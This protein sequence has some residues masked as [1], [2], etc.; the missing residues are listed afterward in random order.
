VKIVVVHQSGTDEIEG[1]FDYATDNGELDV[2]LADIVIHTYPRGEWLK[3]SRIKEPDEKWPP[4]VID[5]I[6]DLDADESTVSIKFVEDAETEDDDGLPSA[7]PE[8]N[9]GENLRKRI[10]E[11]LEK[12]KGA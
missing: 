10:D 8:L 6:E 9:F 3:V 12:E 7:I 2:L 4:Q 5:Q 1:A 11:E